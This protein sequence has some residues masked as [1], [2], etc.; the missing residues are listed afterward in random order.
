MPLQDAQVRANLTIRNYPSGHMIYLDGGSRTALK[1]DLAV[2]YDAL[3]SNARSPQARDGNGRAHDPKDNTIQPYFQLRRGNGPALRPAAAAE[4]APWQIGDLCKAYD[5]P[6]DCVGGG[7]IAIIEF[8]GGWVQGDIDTFFK[9]ASLPL[10]TITDVSLGAAGNNPNQHLGDPDGDPDGEVA[11]DIEIAAAAYSIATGQAAN[12]RVYWADATD[13]GS[14]AAAITAAAADGCDVCSISWGSDEANWQTISQNTGVDYV[15]Q[16]NA[17]AQAATNSGMIVFAAA[18]RQQLVRR[19]ARSLQRGFALVEPVRHWMR[20]HHED[21]RHGDC[22]EQQSRQSQRARHRRRVLATVPA[23]AL[24]AG[25]R[26]ARAGAHGAGRFG[27]CRSE[28]RLSDRGAWP[29]GDDRRH[30]RGGAAHCR[31][32][33]GVRP[34][35]RVRDTAALAQSDLFQ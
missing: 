13:W 7:V 31:P 27:R 32:V 21:A 18:G 14:M 11:L 8:G 24:L 22:M 15:L 4:A 30:E 33:R 19:W 16:L 25:G 29:N 17:A 34:Q 2:M 20:R 10:P 6:N 5:W 26:A 23:D 9:A 28:H 1:A 12:I 35:A 3:F